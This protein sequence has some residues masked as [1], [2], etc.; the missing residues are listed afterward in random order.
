MKRVDVRRQWVPG[1]GGYVIAFVITC[2]LFALALSVYL[3][4]DRSGSNPQIVVYWP[5]VAVACGVLGAPIGF[6]GAVV[7]H[8]TC[9]DVRTEAIHVLAAGLVAAVLVPPWLQLLFVSDPWRLRDWVV[10]ALVAGVCGALGR[11]LARRWIRSD[12]PPRR[13]GRPQRG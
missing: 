8:Y 11:A 9:R 2:A 12:R 6:L 5:F 13:P 4:V 1:P 7:V 10:V 3:A